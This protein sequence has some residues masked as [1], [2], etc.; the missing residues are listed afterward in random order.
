MEE[1]SALITNATWTV[2]KCGPNTPKL[3][4][5]WVYKKKRDSSGAAE[6]YKARLVA[7]GDEQVLGVNYTLT[8]AAVLEMTSGK[9]IFAF[10][11]I[12][13]V[14]A[15]HGDVPNAYVKAMT[16][17]GIEI[18]LVIPKGMDISKETM[19][20]LG[21]NDLKELGLRL[22]RSLYGLKQAGRLW[23]SLLHQTLVQH[24]FTQCVTDSCLY[25]KADSS[26]TT[27][28]GTYVD[29]L[30]VTGTSTERVDAFFAEMQVLSLKDLGPATM[31]LGVSIE[32]ENK[33]GYSF[34]QKHAIEEMLQKHGLA[35]AHS[36]RCPI[37]EEQ[38]VS[39]STDE[40]LPESPVRSDPTVPTI[41]TFQ[42]LVGALLW[43][44]R[45]TRPDIAFAVHR[46]TRHTHAPTLSDWKLAKRIA[47]Y[48]AGSLDLRFHMVED[49]PITSV[50]DLVCYTDAD[51]G[52]D[53]EDRKSVSGAVLC[54]NGLVVGWTCK[55]QSSV[56]LSTA[57]A[58]FVAASTAAILQVKNEASSGRVKHIDI[59]I[60]FLRDYAAKGLVEPQYIGTN[61]MIADILT[62]A[63]PAP[64]VLALRTACGLW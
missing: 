22:D 43:I 38:D 20:D 29:D 8:F 23:H 60:K 34:G 26:G 44:T 52:G 40:L 14:R 48:L 57:E 63:L 41:K 37:G 53:R 51:F 31:F 27:L 21:A 62:K 36:V 2:I 18:V 19:A 16:E 13:G 15:R 35:Q 1:L 12:W 42:S 17:E 61:D 49:Q 56:S 55:K 54:M 64:R 59:M 45:C 25:F 24:G 46:A 3:H 50:I 30:L 9:V 5:K 33:S 7:C 58:E 28:V 10:A 39:I 47:R 32:Y 11:R 4:S 6:R